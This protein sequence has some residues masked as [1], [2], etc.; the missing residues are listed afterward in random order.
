MVC[1]F[2]SF[3]VLFTWRMGWSTGRGFGPA[4][5]LELWLRDWASFGSDKPLNSGPLAAEQSTQRCL[6]S[7]LDSTVTLSSFSKNQWV[8]SMQ[9]RGSISRRICV[10]VLFSSGYLFVWARQAPLG[11]MFVLSTSCLLNCEWQD[12]SIR[13]LELDFN[14]SSGGIIQRN[15]IYSLL[16]SLTHDLIHL[17]RLPWWP[18]KGNKKWVR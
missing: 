16:V 6:S 15:V 8:H 1:V 9:S 14:S 11:V 4:S 5:A 10:A 17:T 12:V 7:G 18:L 2:I 3:S 13:G